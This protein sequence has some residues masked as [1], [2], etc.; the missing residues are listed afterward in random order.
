MSVSGLFQRLDDVIS[1]QQIECRSKY[2]N[3]ATIYYARPLKALQE[4]ER[5]PFFLLFL[6]NPVIF[7]TVLF[8]LTCNGFLF[9]NE[10]SISKISNF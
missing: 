1:S 2:E 3:S 7:I 10:L 8:M 9:L 6:E 4:Y 5:M